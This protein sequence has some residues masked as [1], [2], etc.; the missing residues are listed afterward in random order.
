MFPCGRRRSSILVFRLRITR[1]GVRR[2]IGYVN[3]LCTHPCSREEYGAV[4]FN[5]K[6]GQISSRER[7]SVNVDAVR[8]K[9]NFA[10]RAMSV[11]DNLAEIVLAMKELIPYPKQVFLFL[12]SEWNSRPHTRV[13]EEEISATKRQPQSSQE[14]AVSLRQR[15]R[16]RL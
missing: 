12:L 14:V 16:E 2:S 1:G 6:A 9:F 15:I 10:N 13:S 3:P 7:P 8:M 5:S 4:R 11:N